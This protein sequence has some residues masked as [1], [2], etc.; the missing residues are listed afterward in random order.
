M[1]QKASPSKRS[2][3]K[4][5]PDPNQ[6]EEAL[7]AAAKARAAAKRSASVNMG[8]GES[9]STS[10]STLISAVSTSPPLPEP[11][12]T[13]EKAEAPKKAVAIAPSS[14]ARM[15]TVALSAKN[16]LD[17]AKIEYGAKVSGE[18]GGR[19]GVSLMLRAAILLM[20]EQYEADPDAVIKAIRLASGK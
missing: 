10:L 1:P 5:V 6:R 2:Q 7:A 20:V 19:I 4:P 11:L 16:F 17:L 12:E 15:Q 3:R 18:V 14:G 8:F 13:V 9:P